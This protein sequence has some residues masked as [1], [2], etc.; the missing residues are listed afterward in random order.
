MNEPPVPVGATYSMSESTAPGTIVVSSI[1][2]NDPDLGTGL[3]TVASF[4]IIDGNV[5]NKFTISSVSSTTGRIVLAASVDFESLLPNAK[6]YSLLVKVD[7]NGIPVLSS[8]ATIR[9]NVSMHFLEVFLYF[10]CL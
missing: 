3:G 6:F 4:F 2:S 8:T 5:G 7:D 9:I 1:V 10:P